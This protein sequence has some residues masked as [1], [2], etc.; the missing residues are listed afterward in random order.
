MAFTLKG[1]EMELKNVTIVLL[2]L[3]LSMT[4][5][6]FAAEDNESIGREWYVSCRIMSEVKSR[7]S[8]FIERDNNIFIACCQQ[9]VATCHEET[10]NDEKR[11][12]GEKD[13]CEER[14]MY[15]FDYNYKPKS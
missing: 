4:E 13:K 8:G 6:S 3:L 5:D 10:K 1:Q 14:L 15:C 11:K 2:L 9:K 12:F 7:Y